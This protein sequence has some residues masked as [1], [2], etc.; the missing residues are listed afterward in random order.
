[1]GTPEPPETSEAEDIGEEEVDV[2]DDEATDKATE[3]VAA[4]KRYACT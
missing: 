3:K 1:M 4:K 2:E